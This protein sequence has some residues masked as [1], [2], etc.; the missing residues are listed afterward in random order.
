MTNDHAASHIA[1][2]PIYLV[3]C[4][5]Q[6]LDHRAPAAELYRSDWFRKARAYVEA[7]GGR[8]FILSAAH[9]LVRPDQLLDPYDVTLRALSAQQ[10][11][12]WGDMT[13]RQLREAIG[14]DQAGP[15]V[16]LA[17]QLYREPLLD[18][19]GDR[20]VIPMKGMRIGEQKAWL[21]IQVADLRAGA[22]R[23]R[24]TA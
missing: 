6:K 8:W 11:R 24:L 20:A 12:V 7:M 4:V 5:G 3:A 9:G 23:S 17:G 2:D 15:V 16:F 10:R 19:A 22:A 14:A 1:P 18:L 13:A 21:A